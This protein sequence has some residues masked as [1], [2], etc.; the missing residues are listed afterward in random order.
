MQRRIVCGV[1]FESQAAV[2]AIV[3]RESANALS[4]VPISVKRIPLD[5]HTDPAILRAFLQGIST[6]VSDH[7]I[8]ALAIRK[9]TYAGKY[10]SGAPSIKMEGL[11][12]VTDVDTHLL[13]TQAIKK[14][15]E[16]SGL[17]YPTT[18]AK[19]QHPAFET[20]VAFLANQGNS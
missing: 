8:D 18:L 11:L 7:A 19:F 9:C 14:A 2:L 17:E 13:T 4:H 3:E 10:Q 16:A 15:F 20:A 5:D 6:V 1:S 12:L